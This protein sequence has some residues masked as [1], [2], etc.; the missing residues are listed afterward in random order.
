MNI[1]G[2]IEFPEPWAQERARKI[3]QALAPDNL[4]SM[5]TELT[6]DKVSVCFHSVKIGSLLAS[7]DD[8]LLNFKIGEGVGKSLDQ[9]TDRKN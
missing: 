7:L 8:F 2:S 6:G 5:Q 1:K 9:K 4:R 3:L